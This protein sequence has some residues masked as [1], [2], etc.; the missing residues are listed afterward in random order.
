[1]RYLS[2]P[3]DVFLFLV[4]RLGVPGHAELAMG[5][6][7]AGGVEVLSEDLIRDIGIPH[8]LVQQ[9]AVR[10]RLELERRDRA[11]RDDRQPPIVCDRTVILIDDGLATGSTIDA[12]HSVRFRTVR[13][14]PCAVPCVM[15]I[16]VPGRKRSSTI[17]RLCMVSRSNPEDGDVVVCLRELH[18]RVSYVMHVVPGADQFAYADHEEATARAVAY[19]K[20]VSV[21]AW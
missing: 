17:R 8:A 2:A 7:A 16:G 3:L 20:R 21:N 5:A 6:I 11:Y 9:V 12:N 13:I 15:P 14:P 4:R 18:A 1:M 10:E 19:A